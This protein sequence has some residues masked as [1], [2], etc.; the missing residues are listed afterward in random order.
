MAA[1]RR[2]GLGARDLDVLLGGPEADTPA[3]EGELQQLPVDRI[4]PGRFQPRQAMDPERLQ[5]LAASIRAQ[6]LIQPIVVRNVAGGGYE[7]IAGERRLR[8]DGR[9]THAREIGHH[10]QRRGIR[11][12]PRG[13]G[14]R[15]PMESRASA[16]LSNRQRIEFSLHK[17]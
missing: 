6:G 15:R 14:V 10:L 17:E 1:R 4:R 11:G 16:E 9:R 13:L 8:P 12:D 7:L 3:P 5:E 2:G